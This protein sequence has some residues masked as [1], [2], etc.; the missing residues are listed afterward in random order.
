MY[1]RRRGVPHMCLSHFTI[2]FET[3]YEHL[4]VA[5]LSL[6]IFSYFLLFFGGVVKVSMIMSIFI[7][8]K[9]SSA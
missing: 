1:A 3:I 5:S 4:H 2:M 8:C 7:T 9:L 6:Y